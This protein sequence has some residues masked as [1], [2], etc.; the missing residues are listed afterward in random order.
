MKTPY[1]AHLAS[2]KS[3]LADSCNTLAENRLPY[4]CWNCGH[5][6]RLKHEDIWDKIVRCRECSEIVANCILKLRKMLPNQNIS[7]D[8][9]PSNPG[10]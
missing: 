4:R 9:I 3:S 6:M 5:V 1:I 8:A 7:D 10:W 2:K